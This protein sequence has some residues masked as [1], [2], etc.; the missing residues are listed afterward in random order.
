LDIEELREFRRAAIIREVV[1]QAN[2]LD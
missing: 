1:S 2:N